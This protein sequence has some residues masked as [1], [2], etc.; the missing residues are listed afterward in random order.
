MKC[1]LLHRIDFDTLEN[2]D[3]VRKTQLGLFS[4]DGRLT[5][6]GKVSD[7]FLKLKPVQLYLGWDGQIYP[8]FELEEIETQ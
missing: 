3:P 6:H 7:F 1:V 8:K 5:A 4:P 2:H